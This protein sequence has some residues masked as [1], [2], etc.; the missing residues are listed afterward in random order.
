[1]Q[2]DCV[3]CAS[4]QNIINILPF[5]GKLKIGDVFITTL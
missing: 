4:E 3:V 1:M 5:A 2:K